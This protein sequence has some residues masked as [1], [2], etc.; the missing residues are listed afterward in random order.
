M[1]YL[2]GKVTPKEAAAL[3]AAGWELED[4]DKVA[5]EACASDVK[6]PDKMVAVFVDSDLFAIMTGTDWEEVPINKAN[7]T[8][9]ENQRYME[10]CERGKLDV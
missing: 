1:A 5:R 9:E 6:D 3:E 10:A 4:P 7:N 2:F 8:S